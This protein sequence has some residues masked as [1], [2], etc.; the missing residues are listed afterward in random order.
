MPPENEKPTPPMTLPS[1]GTL[2]LD[3]VMNFSLHT[4]WGVHDPVRFR[5]LMEEAQRLVT[6]GFYLGD[7]LFTWSRNISAIEDETFRN[8]LERNAQNDSDIAIAWRRYILACAAFH[9]VHLAG[10]F[11]EC[12]VLYGTGIKT[13]MDYLGGPTFPKTFWGYDTY[14][15][16]PVSSHAQAFEGQVAGLY[17]KVC[18]RFKDYHQVCLIKGL[19]PGSFAQGC[20]E[21]VAYLHID[22]NN[23][24][25]E[26]SV[27]N[28]LF[29]RVV[30]G[31][32]IILD[33]Y[34]WSGLYRAQKKA[35]DPWFEARGYRVFP[36]PTGQGLVLKR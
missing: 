35:E 7:N 14:D 27:L 16:N 25:S 5:A 12:G 21:Q 36:L 18:E 11:V 28:H 32:V 6:M 2:D 4:Y 23:A 34:E 10:D 8:V 30:A 1:L 26:I 3:K 29:D 19:L 24:E 31:G 33:D 22:L 9:C 15:Y 13:T 17:D 20:P